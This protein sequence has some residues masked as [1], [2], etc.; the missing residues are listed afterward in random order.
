MTS[1]GRSFEHNIQQHG[2]QA[3]VDRSHLCPTNVDDHPVRGP[4][5]WNWQWCDRRNG[6]K[7][8]YR[9]AER[10]GVH[11][12]V[13]ASGRHASRTHRRGLPM[14]SIG[15]AMGISGSQ[16]AA[17]TSGVGLPF[18]VLVLSFAV[19]V[20][21]IDRQASVSLRRP[22]RPRTN[23]TV[24]S[25]ANRRKWRSDEFRWASFERTNRSMDA[26]RWPAARTAPF[27]GPRRTALIS[28]NRAA[29]GSV[30]NGLLFG[31]EAGHT[32]RLCFRD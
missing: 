25:R 28:P 14:Y 22:S 10:T 4:T 23:Q 21:V 19:L 5:D 26:R 6:L 9:E 17:G 1:S 13:R 8:V 32:K 31:G 20:L 15:I 3:V 27:T 2:R 29:R 30:C 24:T 16:F 18:S 7:F 11:R 12:L